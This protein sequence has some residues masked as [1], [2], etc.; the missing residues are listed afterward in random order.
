MFINHN[1]AQLYA[2]DFGGGSR[3]ILAQGGWTG[4]WELWS[5]P[6]QVLSKNW[7]TVAYDHRGTGA[8]VAP[9]DS[10]SIENLV[11]DLFAVMDAM[12]IEKC[13]LAAESAGGIIAVTAVLQH[14][15]CFEGLV[16]VDALLHKEDGSGD[17]A[18]IHGLKTNFHATLGS[19][20]D[21]CVPVTEPHSVEIRSWGKKILAR[22]TPESA[23]KLLECNHGTD[24]RSQLAQIQIPTLIIHGDRDVI[25][26][27]EDAKFMAKRI[28]NNHLYILNGAG[29]VPTMTRP[30]EVAQLINQTFSK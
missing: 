25:V 28:P 16:L 8:T 19:F 14:P 12:K 13:V 10:I 3:T 9:V 26:P 18:F 29:H 23:V 24:L 5:E 22:A 17:A 7:R 2:V 21:A 1:S 20:A 4:S 15:E 27:P 6:F 11:D 30:D